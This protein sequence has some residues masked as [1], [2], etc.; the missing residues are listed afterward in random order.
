MT[1][2]YERAIAEGRD[3]A[4]DDSDTMLPEQMPKVTELKYIKQGRREPR[5]TI[6]ADSRKE[7]VEGIAALVRKAAYV[8]ETSPEALMQQIAADND[9]KRNL[10][11]IR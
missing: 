9:R 3:P 10:I 11:G 2:P 1:D 7:I 4:V 5:V 8:I 6:N